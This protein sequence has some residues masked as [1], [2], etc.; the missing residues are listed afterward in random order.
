MARRNN[1]SVLEDLM[2]LTAKLPWWVGAILALVSYVVL[3]TIAARPPPEMATAAQV[4]EGISHAVVSGLAMV[5]QYLLPFI[6]SISALVS[7]FKRRKAGQLHDSAAH[8]AD[9]IARM[10]WSEFE[11]LVGEYFRRQGFTTLNNGGGG[12]DG[13]VDVLLQ[14]GSDRYLVQC[15]HWRA[16][17]VG[18]PP[19]RELYGVMAARR[20]AGGFVVTSGEFTEEAIR[21]ADGRE[22]HLIDGKALQRGIR[23]QAASMTRPTISPAPQPRQTEPGPI[24]SAEST[25]S[26]PLCNTPMVLR[27]TRNGPTPGKRFWGCSNFA[28]TKCRGTRE[29]V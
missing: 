4:G 12:P 14:K 2:E 7:F 1:Q 18:A 3:H 11:T 22:I 19:V 23:A 5:G 10:S 17:R 20:V 13:G 26:C 15:K 29:M 25:P 16:L 28:E 24:L 8:R 9:G 6:F 27:Q 21:F